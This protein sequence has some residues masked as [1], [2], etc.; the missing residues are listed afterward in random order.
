LLPTG[1][2]DLNREGI[3]IADDSFEESIGRNLD[4]LAITAKMP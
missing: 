3:E 1:G 4:D 2:P